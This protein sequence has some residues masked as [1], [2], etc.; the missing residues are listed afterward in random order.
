MADQL[1]L[2][3]AERSDTGKGAS[4][5][6]RKQQQV[7]GIVYGG[8]KKPQ[9]VSVEYR[10]LAKAL[11]NE[12][13][14]SQVFKLEVDGKAQQVVLRDLQRHPARGDATHADFLRVSA[15]Q[16]ITM[17]IPLHF[18]NEE[19][20]VGVKQQ[21]GEVLRHAAEVEVISLPKDLPEAIEVDMADI[22]LGGVVHLS[23]LPLPD[24]VE[25]LAL[26]HGEE[27]DQP[28]AAVHKP[29]GLVTAEEEAEDAADA[30]EAAA[31]DAAA[32][33]EGGKAE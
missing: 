17:S 29:K 33:E 8:K 9:M 10:V 25:I 20:S 32:K 24:G 19:T 23:D 22:E 4:R 6:L 26:T 11:E 31:E 18:L 30:E 21:G 28:V 12:S 1:V 27:Y 16:K 5:R 13:F 15:K 7:P 2:P 14:Y 3:A